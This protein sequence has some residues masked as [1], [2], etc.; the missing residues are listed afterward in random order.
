MKLSIEDEK[1]VFAFPEHKERLLKSVPEHDEYDVINGLMETEFPLIVGMLR[2]EN[3]T[4]TLKVE[5]HSELI[6][7]RLRYILPCRCFVEVVTGKIN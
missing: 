4:L 5:S 7:E 2:V 6:K 3:K 1:R